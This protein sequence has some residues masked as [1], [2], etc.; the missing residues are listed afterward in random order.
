MHIGSNDSDL[1]SPLV[2]THARVQSSQFFFAEILTAGSCAAYC[3]GSSYLR[4]SRLQWLVYVVSVM[5]A[6]CGT[7]TQDVDAPPQESL[8]NGAQINDPLVESQVLLPPRG[9][10]RFF[11]R[12]PASYTGV[13]FTV[14]IDN[15]HP[16]K[17][18]YVSGFVCGGVTIADVDG[19]GLPDIYLVSGP[20]SNRLYRNQGDFRFAD[21]TDRAGVDGGDAWGVGVATVDIDNDG[22]LDIYVCNY[23]SPNLL[24]LNNGD[25]T[26]VESANQFGLDITDS[27]LMP[28]FCD[29]D[30]DGDLDCYLLTNQYVRDG[31]LPSDLKLVAKHGQL[32][33]PI[34]YQK[35]YG[36]QTTGRN[37]GELQFI[38]RPD[39]LLQQDSSGTF[40]D[41]SGSAG[42]SPQPGHGLSATWWDYNRD[43]LIDLYVAN[44]YQDPD[45]FYRNNGDGTFT[46]VV[47][48]TVPHT[49]W[50]SMGADFGDVNNDGAFDFLIA[51]MSST[52]HFGEKTTMGAMGKHRWFLEHSRPPQY[53]RNALYLNTNTERFMEVAYLA[54]LAS[55]D[56]TWTV[57][58]ADLDSDGRLD[59]L[60]TNGMTRNLNDSDLPFVLGDQV[61]RNRWELYEELPA[62][63]EQNMVYKNEGSLQFRDVSRAWGLDHVGMSFAAAKGD[64]DGDGDLDLVVANL[65]EPVSLY[66]NQSTSGHRVVIRLRGTKSNRW[67]LGAVVRANTSAGSHIRQLIPTRGFLACDDPSLHFGLGTQTRIEKLTVDWPCGYRQT[68]NDL[69]AGH[70]YTITEPDDGPTVESTL[71]PQPTMFVRSAAVAGA[72][73]RETEFDDY[74]RQ[75]L[76]PCRHSQLGP[77]VACGDVDGDGDD[78]LFL[79]GAAGQSGSLYLNRGSNR[80][81]VG[82]AYPFNQDAACEDMAPLFFE[83]DGDGDLDLY[84]T[85]GGVEC[86]PNDVRLMDRLYLNDGHGN[87]A[88]APTGTLP[89]IAQSSGPVAAADFDRD[90]DLDLLIGGRVIPG[91]YPLAPPSRLLRNEGGKLI[92]VTAQLAPPLATTGM[93]TAALWSDTDGDGWIDLLLAHEWGPITLL[94]NDQGRL[95]DQTSPAGFNAHSGWWN[96]IAGRDLDGDGDLDYVATNLGLNTKYHATAQKPIMLYYGD[97]ENAGRMRL[98]EAEFEDDVLFPMRGKSCSSKAMPFLEE[99]FMS[100]KEFALASLKEVYTTESLE[101]SH[102][103][104]ANTFESGIFWNDSTGRFDF[105]PLPRLAQAS[106]AYGVVATEVDG[107][108]NADIYIVQNFFGPQ[109]ETGRMDGGLSL[110]LMGNGDRSFEALQ[111][112]VSGLM[113]PGDAKGLAETDLNSDGWPDFIV[114]MN[115]DD[116]LAF[117]NR[118]TSDR[119]TLVIRLVGTKSNPT[120]IGARVTVHRSRGPSQTAEVQSGSGYLS[121][122][123]DALTFGLGVDD[124]VQRIEVT[125]PDGSRS[126]H[127][128]SAKQR[129]VVIYYNEK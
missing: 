55:S 24:Y 113:V 68:M 14:P 76:L 10:G 77:G 26:F 50:F 94:K 3:G 129:T 60:F 8:L 101:K 75:P 119:R 91:Q 38:G 63:R 29:Y 79:A 70:R 9:N 116:L 107:D 61:G 27:S 40:T 54:N 118:G 64:L 36:M 69:P 71:E 52:T 32:H 108:G 120:A 109:P 105:R 30:R 37:R 92:D 45:H 83:A 7:S 96:G 82:A 18:L 16:L 123:T 1:P 66:R 128:A 39:R 58:L 93:V 121:Q 25:A 12:L 67:G 89:Q 102:R 90:G 43:G 33:L 117:E 11:A 34:E 85:S 62:M 20:G 4:N 115:D 74:Q 35:F 5:L 104:V 111:P 99:K 19:D 106:P 72:R 86:K 57:K 124:E 2:A 112:A 6:G 46:D 103:F 23:D 56:W 122:S 22:D 127:R 28:A 44:D 110:L 125:W 87:F 42:I 48:Q 126:V 88:K 100:Y 95:V 13:D 15:D 53:M 47:E 59:A 41:V 49:T 17:R 81:S 65:E 31:G 51:D 98:V 97:F 84:V 80:F 73:H 114:G 21:I 78:D